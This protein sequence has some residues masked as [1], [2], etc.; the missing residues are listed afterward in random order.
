M[1]LYSESIQGLRFRIPL[2]DWNSLTDPPT[3]G[4]IEEGWGVWTLPSLWR[5][6]LPI[7]HGR[8]QFLKVKEETHGE[9]HSLAKT[10]CAELPI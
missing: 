7:C 5:R 6:E 3:F 8:L 9:F 10:D 1:V 4:S 2:G